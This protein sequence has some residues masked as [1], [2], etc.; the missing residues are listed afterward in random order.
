MPDVVP[1]DED[2]VRAARTRL[3]N[4]Q[5][6]PGIA[7]LLAALRAEHGWS[8][9]EKRLKNLLTTAGLR[10]DPAHARQQQQQP[11]VPVSSVD[12]TVPLPHG[13]RAVYFDPVKGRGLVATK[14]FAQGQSVWVEDAYVAAPPPSQLAKMLSGE[15]CTHCFLPTSNSSLAVAC[16]AGG[17]CHAR[18]CNRVCLARA[19]AAHHPLLCPGTNPAADALLQHLEQYQWH[20]L[21]TVAR[22]LSRLLLTASAHP[23]PSVSPTTGAT[24]HGVA[25]K[26]APASFAETLHHLD[27]F[28]TVSELERRAR[29]PGWDVEA[30]MFVPALRAAHELLVRTLDPREPKRARSFPVRAAAFPAADLDRVFSYDAF[31]RYVAPP[32]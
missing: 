28:A 5:P 20:S 32:H 22:A 16:A 18:F 24:V 29:N 13:V 15:L 30:R 6:A 31:L 17:K 27:A 8:L 12:E 25:T 3:E 4:T 19:Q 2:V 1:S 10:K 9:S 11:W 26:D 21:H 14:P 7:K 23:P